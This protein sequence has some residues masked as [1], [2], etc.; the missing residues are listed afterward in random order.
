MAWKSLLG[1][2]RK[3]HINIVLI[4]WVMN[5]AAAISYFLWDFMTK[6]ESVKGFWLLT[7]AKSNILRLWL[8]LSGLIIDVWVAPEDMVQRVAPQLQWLQHNPLITSQ[9]VKSFFFLF[10]RKHKS[11]L[12]I[13]PA[14]ESHWRLVV[15]WNS[16][17]VCSVFIYQQIFMYSTIPS[18]LL[19]I[20]RCDAN[21]NVLIISGGRA[22]SIFI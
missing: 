1:N 21:S 3:T 11:S 19:K 6:K 17:K 7:D 8:L 16:P 14:M 2:E 4:L 15:T 20:K 22:A 12:K 18:G 13:C 9:R 10:T 5:Y